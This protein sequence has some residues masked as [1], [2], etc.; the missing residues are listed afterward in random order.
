MTRDVPRKRALLIAGPTASG[1][2]ALA[3]DLARRWNGVIINA[4]ALQVYAPLRILTARP[5]PEE[6]ERI[7]HRL[8]G[9]VGATA[10]YSVARWLK[11]VRLE[12]EACWERGLYPVI[13]GGT[14][15][16][17]RALERGLAPVPEIAAEVRERWR[18]FKGDLHL[19]LMRRDQAMAQ[20]LLPSDRQ[21]LTRAL[22][23]IEAT[24]RSLLDWQK[25]GQAS[26]PLAG[27]AVERLFMEVPRDELYARAEQRFRLMMKAGALDEVRAIMHLD[28]DLPMMKAIGVPELVAHLRGEAGLDAAVADAI[29][30]TRNF[31]KRQLTWWR[32]QGK[33]WKRGAA[34]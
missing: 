27:V 8:Y 31:I 2:S 15:L 7:P 25:E 9:H 12:I 21:R 16:Y 5:T 1:K 3:L 23:V 29:T 22:E 34:A 20:R 30:A 4:D 18:S 6:E 24:G 26:A 17:F 28:A 14:G 11:E 33:D 10:Q 32:G 13:V 19:E